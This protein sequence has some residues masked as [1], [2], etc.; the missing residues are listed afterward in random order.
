MHFINR[1]TDPIFLVL[2]HGSWPFSSR[3]FSVSFCY[4]LPMKSGVFEIYIFHQYVFRG[5]KQLHLYS[6]I[7]ARSG[8]EQLHI[9]STISEHSR[10]KQLQLHSTIP[11]SAGLEQLHLYSTIP[12]CSR[13]QQLIYSTIPGRPDWSSC[14]Y[15]PL[16][17]DVP[18]WSSCI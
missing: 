3:S 15:T 1:N 13:L 16:Y 6:T 12:V 8:L 18:G 10:L 2:I 17:L 5:L 4:P 14:I 7:R 9:N 11:G